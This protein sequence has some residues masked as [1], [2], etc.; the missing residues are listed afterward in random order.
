VSRPSEG[1]ATALRKRCAREAGR[2]V[3]PRG[4][5]WECGGKERSDATPLCGEVRRPSRS[6]PVSQRCRGLPKALP[7]HSEGAARGRQ[8]VR[9][10]RAER[11]G[12]AAGRSAATPRRCA[13]RPGQSR[14]WTRFRKRCRGLPKALPPQSEGAP[15]GRQASAA[16]RAERRGSAGGRSVSDAHPAVRR[17]P[18]SPVATPGFE[19]GV[20]AF[21]RPC[22]RS[23]KALRAG[24]RPRRSPARSAVG[25]RGVGASATPTPLCDQA[26]P[27]PRLD[28][29][30]K[31]VSRPSEGLATAVRRRRARETG[32]GGPITRS[33]GTR[34]DR[35][36]PPSMPGRFRRRCRRGNRC[37]GRS[38]PSRRG[39]WVAP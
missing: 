28:P 14:G 24:D 20:A 21:R 30:S 6:H 10:P 9:S 29:V 16:S 32:R 39:R 1:L 37:R 26:R 2:A 19:S 31:A 12:S 27:T 8:V 33:A 11:R 13:T 18:A 15:R 3:P 23:P 25:V 5:P 38:T 4:A 34:W 22:H 17:G 35:G 36:S 7:P